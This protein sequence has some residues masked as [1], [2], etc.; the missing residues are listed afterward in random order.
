MPSNIK[1]LEN[2]TYDTV[3]FSSLE[4]QKRSIRPSQWTRWHHIQLVPK[5]HRQRIQT[6]RQ[7]HR[8]IQVQPSYKSGMGPR[9]QT[10]HLWPRY[11][12]YHSNSCKRT[13]G[14]GMRTH[15]QNLGHIERFL[16]RCRSILPRPPWQKLVL[17]T[18]EHPHR[19]PQ[20]NPRP[21]PPTSQHTMISARCP[22]QEKI[23]A[24]H[25]TM[26][27][28]ARYTSRPL[29][30]TSTTIKSAPSASESQFPTKTSSNFI[31]RK[32]MHWI[33]W[34]RKK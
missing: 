31:S 2:M 26:S 7:N 15:L 22:C 12:Q 10:W 34:T 4:P 18:E 13:N 33:T 27:G 21:N 11:P 28:T 19:L 30:R 3:R 23:Y 16:P 17:P 8:Q 5:Q 24:W 32:C 1:T 25:N 14:A 9:S 20:H 6:T 29:E